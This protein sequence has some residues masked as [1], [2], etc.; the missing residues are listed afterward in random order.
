MTLNCKECKERL[1]PENPEVGGYHIR[2]KRYFPP[3]CQGC[4]NQEELLTTKL[5]DRIE[6]I[7]AI[8]AEAG[9]VPRRYYDQFKQMG[10]EIAYL[11]NKLNELLGNKRQPIKSGYKGLAANGH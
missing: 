11:R 5:E 8:S 4:P 1:Y 7:E 10:G 2:L 6:N 3:L 9:R